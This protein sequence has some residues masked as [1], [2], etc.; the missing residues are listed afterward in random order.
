MD[1]HE[2]EECAG[3]FGPCLNEVKHHLEDPD[4]KSPPVP[5]CDDHWEWTMELERKLAADPEFKGRFAH[6]L[7]KV[8]AGGEQ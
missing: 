6:E 8:K 4:G 5:L 2:E 1:Q 7:E 3:L